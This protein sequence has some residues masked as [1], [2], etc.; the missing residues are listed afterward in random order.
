MIKC[1][2]NIV[3]SLFFFFLPTTTSYVHNSIN[4]IASSNIYFLKYNHRKV[5]NKII[6]SDHGIMNCNGPQATWNMVA[7]D[8]LQFIR[9]YSL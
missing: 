3:R 1:L 6:N 5:V 9:S 7:E 8:Q 2:Y 4:A